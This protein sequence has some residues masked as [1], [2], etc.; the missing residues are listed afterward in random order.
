[1][2]Q[3]N[4]V[5]M[6]ILAVTVVIMAIL[7]TTAVIYLEDTGIINK[8]KQTVKDTNLIQVTEVVKT[9]WNKAN[10][11]LDPT[12]ADLQQAVND[13]LAMNRI[14][15]E[16]YNIV[17][18]MDDVYVSRDF[19]APVITNSSMAFTDNTVMVDL[20]FGNIDKSDYPLFIDY[21]IK[22]ASITSEE[23]YSLKKTAIVNSGTTNSYTYTGLKSGTAYNVKT[24]VRDV[25]GNA[26]TSTL[27]VTTSGEPET[28]ADT[29]TLGSLIT[30]ENYGDT[31]SY[32]V[33]VTGLAET[34]NNGTYTDWRI[35]YHNEDYVYL[36]LADQ[37]PTTVS[38]NKGITVAS[39]TDEE[40]ALYEK[41]KVGNASKYSLVD[42]VTI[43]DTLTTMDSCQ[44]VAQLIRDYAE[45]ANFNTYGSN[46]VGAIGG[47]TLELFAEGWNS[48]IGTPTIT[49]TT[50]TCGYKINNDYNVEL[51]SEGLYIPS[52][53]FYWLASP[54]DSSSKYIARSGGGGVYGYSYSD[55][56][57][58]RPVVCLKSSIPAT[59]GTG[60]YDFEL[61]EN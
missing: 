51:T 56:Y 22:P 10:S 26:A 48:K 19:K 6:V 34:T 21:Y 44:G 59:V 46:V 50:D 16:E 5:S 43:N 38:L 8:S 2:K 20:S 40:L 39:L 23:A 61:I 41:F 33:T 12:L 37:L 7:A 4:G 60:D 32:S 42:T 13:A 54:S 47:P 14:D 25:N 31:V 30:K 29:V 1:M 45:F 24:V 49:L 17:V 58:I 36:I 35:L 18:T 15:T 9:A 27:N 11:K 52:N 55:S 3:R 28:E 53:Y 57:S